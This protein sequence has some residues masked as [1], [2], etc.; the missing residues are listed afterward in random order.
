MYFKLIF[1]AIFFGASV[2][3]IVKWIRSGT[4]L[5]GNELVALP[6]LLPL[7]VL[8]PEPCG[9]CLIRLS[10]YSSLFGFYVFWNGV[11]KRGKKFEIPL[12][13]F[14]SGA[15]GAYEFVMWLFHTGAG[16][17]ISGYFFLDVGLMGLFFLYFYLMR[18]RH[19][20][21]KNSISINRL[22]ELAV[23]CC[24]FEVL[25]GIGMGV[26]IFCKNC[27]WGE[28]VL[29]LLFMGLYV[30]YIFYEKPLCLEVKQ[31]N[32]LYVTRRK[33]APTRGYGQLLEDD[34]NGIADESIVEDSRIIYALMT[35]FEKE[36]L[37]RNMDIKIANV[38]LMIGTNKT[39]LSRA[40]NARLSKNFCQFVNYYRVREVCTRFLE[41]PTLEMRELGEMCGFSSYSNFSIVFKYNTGFTPGDWGRMIKLKL[42]NNELVS[43]DDYLL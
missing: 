40:L 34:I 15:M 41:N 27:G 30:W 26:S 14:A 11:L 4:A 20:F 10:V 43:V 5:A 42:E 21:L 3:L 19:S 25:S 32:E 23:V 29:L 18:T 39:Y 31:L 7:M 2:Y 24:A 37:Y 8:I 38:A 33:Y 6:L 35:L 9:L 16:V 22:L 1:A 17:H 36:H 28:N 12:F 13:V